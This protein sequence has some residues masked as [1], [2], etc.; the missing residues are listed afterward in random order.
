VFIWIAV[1][2]FVTVMG[3]VLTTD[4]VQAT[5]VPWG[6]YSSYA[7]QKAITSLLL[8]FTYLLPLTVTIF[9]YSRIVYALLRREVSQ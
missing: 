2:A 3:S 7:S 4:I 5:C 6:A 1:P 9:C 8:F